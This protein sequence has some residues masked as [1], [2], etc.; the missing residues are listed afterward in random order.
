MIDQNKLPEIKP[1]SYE[2]S[3][4]QARIFCMKRNGTTHQF[5]W[6]HAR[7]FFQ[8]LAIFRSFNKHVYLEIAICNDCRKIKYVN[9]ELPDINIP[10]HWGKER[11]SLWR[12]L[13]ETENNN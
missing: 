8:I 4:K 11:Q 6:P 12:W 2:E 9:F 3:M 10:A 1:M 13:N 7:E 5:R